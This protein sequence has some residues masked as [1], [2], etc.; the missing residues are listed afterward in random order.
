MNTE[1]RCVQIYANP[2]EYETYGAEPAPP[3]AG[4]RER[5]RDDKRVRGHWNTRLTS[6]EKLVFIKVFTEKQVTA[7]QTRLN[8]LSRPSLLRYLMSQVLS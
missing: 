3:T 7:A 5:D 1:C 4:E 2:V 8:T 6:F